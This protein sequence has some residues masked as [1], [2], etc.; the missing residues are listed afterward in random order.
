MASAHLIVRGDNFGLSHAANQA[1]EEAFE[2][3]ILTCASLAVVGPWVAE[4]AALSHGH[5][6]WEVGLQLLLHCL[7]GGCRWGPVAGP[8]V[9]PSLVDATGQFP[10]AVAA[11]ATA[12]D[13]DRELAAQ[14]ERARAWGLQPAYVEYTG[15][16]HP[17]VAPALHR[18]SEHFGVPAGMTS[19][20]I[21]PLPLPPGPLS[22]A[23]LL[24][25]LAAL[26]VGAYL[27]VTH[28]AHDAPESWA[29]WGEDETPRS[30]QIE[31]DL[32]CDASVRAGLD[33]RGIELMSFRQQLEIRLGAETSD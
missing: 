1:V 4:A 15:S 26:S 11:T 17:A 12:E 24:D 16:P 9:V 28:P 7:P 5:P 29:L 21:Q 19:W 25:T 3:G 33:E 31:T 20:D 30:Q 22:A 14:L 18:L 8:A 2:T 13:V 27:W 32:L 6:E 10:P 23:V